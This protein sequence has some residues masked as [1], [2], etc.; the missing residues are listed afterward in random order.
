MDTLSLSSF[1]RVAELGSFGKAAH[2][3][4][5]SQPTLTRRIALLEKQLG[6]RLFLR[7]PRGVI[8]TPAGAMLQKRA[9]ELLRQHEEIEAELLT[10]AG[11][12]A[13]ILAIGL[14][15]SLLNP[16]NVP[17]I[18]SFCR[19]HPGVRLSIHEDI[20]NV[21][22]EKLVAGTLDIAI[23]IAARTR[24]RGVLLR[25]LATE[26][27][28]LA[29]ARTARCQPRRALTIHDIAEMPLIL[30]QRPNN[31][32]WRMETSFH[33]KG[34]VPKIVAEANTLSMLMELARRG[35]GSVV[36]PKSALKEEDLKLR[37]VATPIVGLSLRWVLAIA[38]ERRTSPPVIAMAETIHAMVRRQ[39][40]GGVWQASRW[41]GPDK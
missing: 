10:T 6:V 7:T 5:V 33:Q 34:L 17:I 29:R 4:H 28:F 41:T 12:L 21:M 8:R 39:I 14:P 22:E 23:M 37:L 32:R 24:L 13:G 1:L 11:R 40:D 30:S 36:L 3:L 31:I 25:T 26:P 20:T 18:E 2:S 35:L 15:P 19:E 16:L 27:L 9:R 38:A